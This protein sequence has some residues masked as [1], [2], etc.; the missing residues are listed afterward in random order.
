VSRIKKDIIKNNSIVL[1]P[2]RHRLRLR[3]GGR[4]LVPLWQDTRVDT[5][6]YL[7][8]FCPLYLHTLLPKLIGSGFTPARPDYVGTGGSGPGVQLANR[9]SERL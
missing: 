8:I 9:S 6:L 1:V 4:V 3:R 2:A 7:L 5:L